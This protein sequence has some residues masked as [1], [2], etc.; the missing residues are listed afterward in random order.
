MTTGFTHESTY[1]ETVE[2]YTPP[3][4]FKALDVQFDLD[5]CGPIDNSLCTWIPATK[6]YNVEDDGLVQ[7]WEG[8]VWFNPPYGPNTGRWLARLKNHNNGIAL[9]F[10][11]TDTEWFH[12]YAAKAKV[13]CFVKGRI[14]F[15]RPTGERAGTPGAGSLLIAYGEECA[16]KLI[17]SKL[18]WMVIQ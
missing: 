11:R 13:L 6:R 7:S 4:I 12:N 3:E 9:V 1:N 14:K 16:K 10:S 18:G 5:P 17:E 2:W 15:V 8:K